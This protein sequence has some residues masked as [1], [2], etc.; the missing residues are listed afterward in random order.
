MVFILA[1]V[2]LFFL[3]LLS[4]LWWVRLRGLC[5]LPDGGTGWEKLGLTLVGGGDRCTKC[6]QEELP[7]I[8]GQGQQPGG[9]HARRTSAKRSYPTS[10][11]RGSGGECQAAMAQELLRGATPHPRSSGCAGTGGCLWAFMVKLFSLKNTSNCNTFSG[12]DGIWVFA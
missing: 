9:P 6:G 8:W 11:V 3:L 7:H 4:T 2:G 5:K 12:L 1:A 10:E